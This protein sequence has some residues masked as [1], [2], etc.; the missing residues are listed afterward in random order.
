MQRKTNIEV[1]EKSVW[2]ETVVITTTPA[3]GYSV[4]SITVVD[5]NGQPIEV[6]ENSFVM[7][8]GEVIVTVEFAKNIVPLETPVVSYEKSGMGYLVSWT[9]VSNASSYNYRLVVNGEAGEWT[10]TTETV[11]LVAYSNYPTGEVKIV[12][13]VVAVGEGDYINSEVVATT[14]MVIS[15]PVFTYKPKSL[16]VYEAEYFVPTPVTATTEDKYGMKGVQFDT[17]NGTTLTWTATLYGAETTATQSDGEWNA[18]DGEYATGLPLDNGKTFLG[19]RNNPFSFRYILPKFSQTAIQ[20]HRNLYFSSERAK[21]TDLPRM[22]TI[23]TN[24]IRQVQKIAFFLLM[25]DQES[26][27]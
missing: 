8:M 23:G 7:P 13:E 12:A 6:T 20:F 1:V 9:E 24:K 3:D 14:E 2:G 26:Q 25:Q 17:A 11:V 19:Y 10:N 16:V 27:E 18:A 22:R 4:R 5:G 21:W 15:D